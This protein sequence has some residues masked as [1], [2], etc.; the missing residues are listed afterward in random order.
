MTLQQTLTKNLLLLLS[1]ATLFLFTG[2]TMFYSAEKLESIGKIQAVLFSTGIS[3]SRFTFVWYA[4]T[5]RVKGRFKLFLS[6]SLI[7]AVIELTNYQLEVGEGFLFY[8]LAVVASFLL[9][10]ATGVRF[11]DQVKVSSAES[12]GK[13]ENHKDIFT[14]F[15]REYESLHGKPPTLKILA[16]KFSLSVHMARKYKKEYDL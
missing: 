1:L 4:I 6:F 2:F 12:G 5:S 3:L 10:F 16:D 13:P 7:V 11:N 14:T 9:E 8:L 15:Y